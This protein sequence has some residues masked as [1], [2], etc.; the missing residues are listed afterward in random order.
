M[1]FRQEL[2]FEGLSSSF[3]EKSS[4]ESDFQYWANLKE[5]N[6]LDEPLTALGSLGQVPSSSAHASTLKRY[7]IAIELSQKRDV[8]LGADNTLR[9]PS[10]HVQNV[11]TVSDTLQASMGAADSVL[12][13]P[14]E[15]LQSKAHQKMVKD[16]LQAIQNDGLSQVISLSDYVGR[17][18]PTDSYTTHFRRTEAYQPYISQQPQIPNVAE[19]EMLMNDAKVAW[20]YFEKW[21]NPKTGLCPAT[22]NFSKTNP[23]LHKAVTM[24]DVGSHIFALLAAVDLK[25]ISEQ[26]F[27]NAIEKILPNIAGRRSQGR[28]LPQG[29][30]VTN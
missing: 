7:G 10:V 2:A 26:H 16:A 20:S 21:T 4:A 24:W 11:R 25:L 1:R 15:I 19:R 3:S 13:I 12:S 18:V 22:A 9:I 5:N 23:R 30:S 14:T 17:L 27:R 28:L 6:P 29:W 8:G